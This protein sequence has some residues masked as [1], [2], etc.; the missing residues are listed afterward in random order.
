M[1][2]LRS[3]YVRARN[4]LILLFFAYP[5]IG[6]AC[7]SIAYRG[8]KPL[9]PAPAIVFFF[10]YVLL[11]SAMLARALRA[12]IRWKRSAVENRGKPG[13]ES[14]GLKRHIAGDARAPQER[15]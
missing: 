15:K 8:S 11:L 6:F 12:R 3:K 9:A 2:G 14:A 1:A 7:L 5:L 13:T 10:S 4:L